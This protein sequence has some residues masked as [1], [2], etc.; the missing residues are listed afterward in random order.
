MKLLNITDNERNNC[1]VT[2]NLNRFEV[3]CGDMFLTSAQTKADL[4]QQLSVNRIKAVFDSVA[5]RK[6]LYN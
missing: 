1:V 3:F 4:K 6:Y 2:Y 5:Q